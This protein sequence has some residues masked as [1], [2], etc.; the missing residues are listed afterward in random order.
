MSKTA[1][2]PSDRQENVVDTRILVI[3]IT[4]ALA[5]VILALAAMAGPGGNL[6][7]LPYVRIPT[8]SAGDSD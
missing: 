5:L 6:G 8:N 7:H 2:P 3:R 1:N 4:L